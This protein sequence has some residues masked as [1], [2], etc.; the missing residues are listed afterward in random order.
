MVPFYGRARWA[1]AAGAP[2]PAAARREG[3]PRAGAAAGLPI[4]GDD[5]AVESAN[6]RHLYVDTCPAIVASEAGQR[7]CA[8]QASWL[9]GIRGIIAYPK[10]AWT[11]AAAW[12]S[13]PRVTCA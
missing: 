11:A 2:G 8:G 1:R 7:R 10:I 9:T 3:P 6:P 5:D 13:M 12:A 4:H